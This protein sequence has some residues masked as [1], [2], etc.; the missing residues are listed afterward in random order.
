MCT[1]ARDLVRRRPASHCCFVPPPTHFIPE[2]QTYS[3]PLFLKR[4]C[5]RTLGAAA[6][7]V[8][9]GRGR[10]APP[11]RARS[12]GHR[13]RS[14]CRFGRPLI[15]VTPESPTFVTSVSEATARPNP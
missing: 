6:A 2:S 12:G 3:V 13:A 7:G 1:D 5:D 9:L 14:H 10:P 8:P 15:H 4:Q 11:A